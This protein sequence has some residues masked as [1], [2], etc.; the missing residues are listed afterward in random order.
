M[1]IT[2][3]GLIFHIPG[4]NAIAGH[5]VSEQGIVDHFDHGVPIVEGGAVTTKLVGH[6][7]DDVD[8]ATA[9][10]DALNL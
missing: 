7:R 10:C 1:T 2:S 5:E 9:I 4:A 6:F 8:F 3:S